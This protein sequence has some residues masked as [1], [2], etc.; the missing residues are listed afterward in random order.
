MFVR[1]TALMLG[2]SASTALGQAPDEEFPTGESQFESRMLPP[3][4]TDVRLGGHLDLLLSY[5]TVVLG[6]DRG[7]IELG[8]GVLSL[9]LELAAGRCLLACGRLGP[10]LTVERSYLAP[11]ARLTYH[12]PITGSSVSLADSGFYVLLLGGATFNFVDERLGTASATASSFAPAVSAGIG[13]TYFPG[14]SDSIFAG[15]EARFTYMP[16]FSVLDVAP[17]GTVLQPQSLSSLT[18][19]S[20]I[21]FMGV[22][23]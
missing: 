23:L 6:V 15:G 13:T 7:L 9:G 18:G 1:L 5:G 4:G 20:L 10:D 12:F 16:R 11:A 17:A 21:F 3:G 22:R 2:V 8:P 19:L 14:N